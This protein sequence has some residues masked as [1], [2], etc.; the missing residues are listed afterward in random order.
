MCLDLFF[1]I[2]GRFRVKVMFIVKGVLSEKFENKRSLA[3]LNGR[4]HV[5]VDYLYGN[6]LKFWEKP[7]YTCINLALKL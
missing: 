4:F 1:S 2:G 7:S 6:I 3:S 5:K